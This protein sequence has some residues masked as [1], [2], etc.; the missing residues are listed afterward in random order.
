MID[1]ASFLEDSFGVWSSLDPE[2][3][4][5]IEPCDSLTTSWLDRFMSKPVWG[6]AD[7][8]QASLGIHHPWQIKGINLQGMNS[9]YW[10]YAIE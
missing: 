6:F 9:A 7:F 8:G 1:L 4:N 3:G 10:S 2:E 5:E